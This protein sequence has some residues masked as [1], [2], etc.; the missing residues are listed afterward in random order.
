[1]VSYRCD[2]RDNFSLNGAYWSM[3]L[4]SCVP[5]DDNVDSGALA[6]S[7]TKLY[8]SFDIH[9]P[10]HDSTQATVGRVMDPE[11]RAFVHLRLV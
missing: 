10:V 7:P 6:V 2:V 9:I 11:C 8:E 5:Y 1:M 4:L 3:K